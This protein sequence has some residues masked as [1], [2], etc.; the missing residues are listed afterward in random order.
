V[1]APADRVPLPIKLFH[2]LGSVAYGIKDNGF[3]TFLLLFYNQV[4][5]L[6]AKLVSL[7][8]ML[9]LFVDAFAD[10]V[11]GHLSDRTYT[12]WGRRLP[13]LYLSPFPLALA[14]MLVW[15]APEGLGSGIFLYLLVVAILV[16]TL[17]SC[18]EVPSAALV[19]E[20]TRD[21][22]ER[23][24]V[25]RYRYLFGWAGGLLMLFLAYDVFLVP[26]ATHKVGQ[27]NE[28]GYWAYGL[29]GAGVI[30]LSVVISALGQHKRVAHLPA[31]RPAKASFRQ[32][33]DEIRESLTHPAAIILLSAAAVAYTSQGITFSISNYLYIFVW[34]FS[35]QAFTWYPWLL[36]G[37][38]GVSFFLVTPL[39]RRF[40]KRLTAMVMGVT[41]LLFWISPFSLNLLGLWPTVGTNTS[42]ILVFAFAFCSNA[43]SVTAMITA[44]SMVAD[45]VEA[46]E[47]KTGRR[48][49]GVFS[50]GW[51]FTQKCGTGLGIF[52]SGLIVSLSGLPEKAVPGA[53]ERGVITNLMLSYI[54]MLVLLSIASTWIFSRFPIN[55]E[56]HEA[57]LRQ[58]AGNAESPA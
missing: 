39:T 42:T 30:I 57:R 44:Q 13:W 1:T 49:E 41:G 16:R 51:L 2:G 25:M 26:D 6:D 43:T 28:A 40:G 38:V 20:L 18:C 56:D 52:F 53:V 29:C 32:S 7:A 19:P 47:I 48:T 34:Q 17:V 37:S 54:I 58:L 31:S 35:A 8:L 4:I 46:S 55:R 36:F 27:L 24:V 50:A 5:G 23:T 11:I 12:S 33:F 9:A 10:P 22:D 15:A 21:Y 45:I 3:S 14:W